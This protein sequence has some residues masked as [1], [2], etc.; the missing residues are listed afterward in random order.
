MCRLVQPIPFML[1][2]PLIHLLNAA[3]HFLILMVFLIHCPLMNLFKVTALPHSVPK[4][5]VLVLLLTPADGRNVDVRETH[6]TLPN[7]LEA[8]RWIRVSACRK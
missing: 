3:S 7:I 8:V 2:T 6:Q 4:D 1:L 5:R